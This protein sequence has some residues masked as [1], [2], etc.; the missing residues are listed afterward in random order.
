MDEVVRDLREVETQL[1]DLEEKLRAAR[2]ELDQTKLR[3]PKAGVVVGSTI[4]TVGGVVVS[5]AVLMEIVP[6]NEPLIVEVRIRPQDIDH[7]RKGE[8][9][10]IRLIGFNARVTPAVDG[11]VTYVSADSLVDRQ[12]STSYYLARIEVDLALKPET[13]N[14]QLQPGMLAQVMVIT[15][16]RTLFDYILSPI[17][18][19]ISG[20]LHET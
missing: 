17:T 19:G 3:A 14:L 5:G 7:V 20:A 8:F 11:R 2:H 13:A 12:T 1:S 9:A 16:T 18:D 4:H 10:S 6:D 15:G